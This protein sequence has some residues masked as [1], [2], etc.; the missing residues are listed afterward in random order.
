MKKILIILVVVLL[1][2]AGSVTGPGT[3]RRGDR[4]QF[5]TLPVMRGDLLIGVTAT[6]TVEPVQIIDVGA[7]IVGMVK[8]FGPDANR[9]GK[10]I[11]YC[12]RVK[13]GDVLAQL[14]DLPASGRAGEGHGRPAAGRG[15]AQAKPRAPGPGGTRLPSGQAAART[16]TRRPNSRP[17]RRNTRSPRRNWP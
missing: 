3:A 11:D 8:S 14:D 4:P 16:R 7:Q 6:G 17:P 15:R 10:T 13:E 1:A 12:S 5:R 2:A 9:P